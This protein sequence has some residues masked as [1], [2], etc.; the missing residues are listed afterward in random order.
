M[1]SGDDAGTIY[2]KVVEERADTMSTVHTRESSGEVVDTKM[3]V[4][5][6]GRLFSADQVVTGSIPT[7]HGG[8]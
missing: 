5:Q 2:A 4:A 1:E 6:L 3:V 8:I 7:Y